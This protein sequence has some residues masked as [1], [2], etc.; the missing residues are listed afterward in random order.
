MSD[1]TPPPLPP[2]SSA[3]AKDPSARTPEQAYNFVA[4][5]IG[6]VP[7][8]RAKDNV[9]QAV[10]VFVFAILGGIIGGA[11]IGWWEGALLG[12]LGGI[13]GGTLLSGLV[14]MIIGLRRKS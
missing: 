4:D 5:K 1:P 13:I 7:N 9:F 8:V 11:T 14:L 12:G 2:G 10:T 3:E 6:G